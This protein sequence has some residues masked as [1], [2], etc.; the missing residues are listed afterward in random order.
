[1]TRGMWR[2]NW[3]KCSMVSSITKYLRGSKDDIGWMARDRSLP[4][5]VDRTEK[6]NELLHKT[7]Y[8]PDHS[9]DSQNAE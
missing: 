7:V 2:V 1:M 3:G 6:F 8:A 5:V 9:S 4:P